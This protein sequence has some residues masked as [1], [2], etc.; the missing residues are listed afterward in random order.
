MIRTYF[1]LRVAYNFAYPV[2]VKLAVSKSKTVS[3]GKNCGGDQN[4]RQ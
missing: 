1:L 4:V 3:F 2:T